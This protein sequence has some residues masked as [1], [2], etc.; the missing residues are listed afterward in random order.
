MIR[1]AFLPTRCSHLPLSILFTN[2]KLYS[3]LAVIIAT[4]EKIFVLYDP[5]HLGEIRACEASSLCISQG[6]VPLETAYLKSFHS[7]IDFIGL[8]HACQ[9]SDISS[10]VNSEIPTSL[11]LGSRS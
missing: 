4:I 9:E 11:F 10:R 3:F 8:D 1:F 6:S 5:A 7:V 2:R